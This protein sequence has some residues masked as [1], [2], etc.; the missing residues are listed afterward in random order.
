M[1]E[2]D[3]NGYIDE[4]DYWGDVITPKSLHE[5]L[6]GKDGQS[7]DDVHIRL[8]SYGGFCNAATRMFD[9]TKA[10]PGKVQITISGTV[11]SAATVLA[12]AADVLEMT[13]G[14]LFMIHDPSTIAFGNERDMQ[15]A[16]NVLRTVKSS[17][18]NVYAT[19]CK[20]PRDEV[21]KLMKG[22]GGGRRDMDGC[23]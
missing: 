13:P 1:R 11:A 19:R 12:Q 17:I 6:Y 18:L 8:N 2:I 5:M 3:L 21:A 16:V 4:D 14:S 23:D 22:V 10:Y 20:L 15:G 7:V 9:D